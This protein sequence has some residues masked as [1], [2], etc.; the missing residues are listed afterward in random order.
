M[1]KTERLHFDR[2]AEGEGLFRE[3][4]ELMGQLLDTRFVEAMIEDKG[5]NQ[6][7]IYGGGYLGIQSCLAFQQ[8][9]QV[10]CIIDRKGQLI[11]GRSDI[12]TPVMTLTQWKND[13]DKKVPVLI[14]PLQ[15]MDE[16]KRD[17]VNAAVENYIGI[18]ELVA[19]L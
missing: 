16:I 5:W 7:Y 9:L 6:I 11:V 19:G 13:H 18:H 2:Y 1:T 14:T 10:L 12:H 3:Y 8:F 4:Y 15:Y 17:L